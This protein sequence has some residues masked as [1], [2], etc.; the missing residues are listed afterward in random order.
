MSVIAPKTLRSLRAAVR[1]TALNPLGALTR[2]HNGELL[3][4]P[5]L[6]DLLGR[7]ATETHAVALALGLP[8]EDL[9][10]LAAVEEVCQNTAGN[11]CSMLQDVLA[12]RRT[13]IQQI[14]GEIVRRGQAVEANVTL[15]E[16][17]VALVEG[18]L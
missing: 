2:R 15:N 8:L 12:G 11:Q 7:V 1:R 13:E 6:R 18:L 4:L 10:P 3:A 17:L 16:A 5:P 14:N 9:D